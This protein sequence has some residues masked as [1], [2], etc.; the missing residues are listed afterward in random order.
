INSGG[1]TAYRF[2]VSGHRLTV[3]HADGFPVD[4]V[5]VD[6]LIIGM[7]ERY[8]VLITAGDGVFP[9]VAAPE[10]KDAAPGGAL[11][12]TGTGATPDPAMLPTEMFGQM[13]TYSALA[14]TAEVAFQPQQPDRELDV[15]LEMIDGGRKWFINGA[16][17][18]DHDPLQISAGER[19]RLNQR[20]ESIIVHPMHINGHTFALAGH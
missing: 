10:G 14:P 8:D 5:D 11:L 20:N 6:T 12:R 13:L 2:A 1:D 15:V 4:P 19:V 17:F 7:G 3:T 16:G 18:G 9:M